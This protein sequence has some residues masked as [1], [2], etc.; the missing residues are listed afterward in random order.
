MKTKDQERVLELIGKNAVGELFVNFLDIDLRQVK[1]S[2]LHLFYKVVNRN[3]LHLLDGQR[4]L[5]EE[6]A[7]RAR[8]LAE[9]TIVVQSMKDLEENS[10]LKKLIK[11]YGEKLT[12]EGTS[13]EE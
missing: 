5:N 11:D 12:L 7:T 9:G 4:V 6:L 13:K 3:I 10:T 8:R 1:T 2:S